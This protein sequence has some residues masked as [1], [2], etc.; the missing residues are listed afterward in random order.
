MAN[1]EIKILT[2]DEHPFRRTIEVLEEQKSWAPQIPT[3]N[4]T[5]V[6]VVIYR[7]H[8]EIDLCDIEC[9]LSELGHFV[10][11]FSNI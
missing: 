7:L 3:S 4:R 5:K 9:E 10:Q 6:S 1:G 2:V 11:N 8:P